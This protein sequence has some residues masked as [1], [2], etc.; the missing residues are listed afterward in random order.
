MT[1]ILIAVLAV[2]AITFVS[3]IVSISSRRHTGSQ[4]AGPEWVDIRVTAM[5]H[6]F[7]F[8]LTLPWL[9]LLFERPAHG[10]FYWIAM[11][12]AEYFVIVTW[13]KSTMGKR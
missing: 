2:L 9:L 7:Y 1:K 11:V 12:V 10:I 13:F 5:R 8:V 6:A 4:G 3:F